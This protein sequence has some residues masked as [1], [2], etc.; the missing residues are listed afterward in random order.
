MMHTPCETNPDAYCRKG[1][2]KHWKKCNKRFPHD[3]Q[4][5]SFLNSMSFMQE[6]TT[7]CE[8][9]YAMPARPENNDFVWKVFERPAEEDPAGASP[10]APQSA[11][12][13]G[14]TRRKVF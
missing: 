11:A 2:K 6:V 8:G 1:Q 7:L 12:S 4:A 10:E 13:T 3:F 9:G 5:R 14:S